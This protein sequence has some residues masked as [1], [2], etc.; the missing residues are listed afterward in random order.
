MTTLPAMKAILNGEEYSI[1][2]ARVESFSFGDP[3]H[4]IFT[5]NL[6]FTG[7]SWGQGLGG[8][9]LDTYDDTLERRI[10]TAY[11]L[12]LIMEVVSRIGSPASAIVRSEILRASPR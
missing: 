8:W 12:D 9:V 1:E 7:N 2:P 4:G 6:K 3:D 5:L 11:G 10:G